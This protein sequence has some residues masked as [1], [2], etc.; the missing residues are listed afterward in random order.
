VLF[1]QFELDG[2]RYAIDAASIAGVLPLI[3]VTR[4]PQAPPA[5]MGVC[6]CRGTPVPVVDLSEL[7]AGRPAERRLSTRLL[8]VRYKDGAGVSRRLGVVAEK[9]TG[10]IRRE[11]SS[12]VPSGIT[13]PQTPYLGDV[14][15]DAL[16]LVQRIDISAVLP[17]SLRE[18]LFTPAVAS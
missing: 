3:D 17:P 12:F 7:L 11:A 14:A 8:I 6:D 15:G 4:I 1:L 13:N 18:M 10:F 9:A 16:G 2:H 5:L